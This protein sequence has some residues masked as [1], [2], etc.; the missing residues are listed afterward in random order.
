MQEGVA[1]GDEVEGEGEG[2]G[3]AEE[4]KPEDAEGLQGI[5]G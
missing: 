4:E 1:Q 5:L 2:E 3:Q